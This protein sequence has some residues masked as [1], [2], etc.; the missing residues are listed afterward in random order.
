MKDD[1]REGKVTVEF[2]GPF[3]VF[4]KGLELDLE[5]EVTYQEFL[6]M[7]VAVLGSDFRERAEKKNTTIIIN[8]KVIDLETASGTTIRPGDRVA[9]AL[10]VGGG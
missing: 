10:L 5:G 9:F 3:R 6:E 7:L 8:K 1:S 4:G 2:F